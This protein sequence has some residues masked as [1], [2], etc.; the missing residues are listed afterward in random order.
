MVERSFDNNIVLKTEMP[1]RPFKAACP[2]KDN[3]NFLESNFYLDDIG[4]GKAIFERIYESDVK[5]YIDSLERKGKQVL[6][7]YGKIIVEYII[8]PSS[9]P[10]ILTPCEFDIFFPLPVKTSPPCCVLELTSLSQAFLGIPLECGEEIWP[11]HWLNKNGREI[12]LLFPNKNTVL[13]DFTIRFLKKS[14]V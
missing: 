3:E 10:T 1:L 14:T 2:L 7:P 8:Q 11:Y 4:V 9:S 6:A 5:F 12:S 13:Q